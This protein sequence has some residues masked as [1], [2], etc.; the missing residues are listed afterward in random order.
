M[1]RLKRI[2][3]GPRGGW[4]G[5]VRVALLLIL[6]GALIYGGMFALSVSRLQHIF[7]SSNAAQLCAGLFISGRSA[8]EVDAQSIMKTG[9]RKR[10]YDS[11]TIGIDRARG[12]V[13]VDGALI[14]PIAAVFQGEQ[15]CVLQPAWSAKPKQ[16]MAPIQRR[17]I[18][19]F[20]VVTRADLP[21]DIAAELDAE[22]AKNFAD[23]AHATHAILV[24][25][26]GVLLREAY[27]AGGGPDFR[28]ESWSL[29]KTLVGT[30]VGKLIAEG[31]LSLDEPISISQWP[32][33]DP[34]RSILVRHAMGMAGGLRFTTAYETF[35]VFKQ[36]DHGLIY[37]DLPDVVRFVTDRPAEHAPGARG[38][39]NNADPLLLL[40]HI[41]QKLNLTNDGL[42]ALI[43]EK[44]FNPLGMDVVLSTDP[45]GFP[46]ITGYVYGTARSW[47]A[48]GVLYANDGRLHGKPFL[49]PGFVA[50]AGTPSPNYPNKAYG[51][52]LWLNN[53][54]WY[55]L[56]KDAMVMA[57]AGDQ[58]VAVLPRDK[59]VLVRMGHRN[60]ASDTFKVFDESFAKIA[61]LL[62]NK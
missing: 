13:T 22:I 61:T 9:F 28:A 35:P 44:V 8:G 37:T 2:V 33:G 54:A 29:G 52:M 53:H 58:V 60:K 27:A 43:R 16:T 4:R 32:A 10:I 7:A 26:D 30:L 18:D 57:G 36:S 21:D 14:A 48:L 42:R 47:G 59:I 23:P 46:I 19:K 6:L 41:R 40:E 50:F 12:M 1:S 11:F 38:N 55:K 51:G 25:K 5:V 56:P 24:Y 17:R 3:W 45:K 20:T 31:K 15:G 34:R 62:A 39:Y 49:A